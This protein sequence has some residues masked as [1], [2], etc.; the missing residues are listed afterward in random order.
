MGT[1]HDQFAVKDAH[2]VLQQSR[3][4]IE[5]CTFLGSQ[6]PIAYVG[7]DGAVVRYNT[8]YHPGKW[9]LRILQETT[10]KGFAP[11]A[12]G[13]F[14]HNL[15]VFRSAEVQ[16]FVNVGPNTRPETFKFTDNLWYCEDRPEASRPML[17]TPEIGGLYGVDPQLQAPAKNLFQPQN[18]QAAQFGAA[19]W[20]PNMASER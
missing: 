5:G 9:V 1:C 14:E 13:R 19:A 11:C 2:R 16:V 15:V 4:L 7:V 18:R 6:A 10:E 3:S 12:G 17:P 8:I 20:Q